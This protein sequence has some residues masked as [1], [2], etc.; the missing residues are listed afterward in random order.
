MRKVPGICDRCGQRYVLRDLR[1][2][3]I[4]GKMTGILSCPSCYDTS[5]PQLDTRR[6]KTNDRQTVK[7]SRSD[8]AELAESRRLSSWNPVG[9]E[10]T[11]Y[12]EVQVGRPTVIIT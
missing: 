2:E 5:H 12:C 4:M 3:D 9:C 10:A 6:V 1:E 8:Q 11:G 7:N